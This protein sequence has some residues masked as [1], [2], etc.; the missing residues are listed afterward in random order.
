MGV[1]GFTFLCFSSLLTI[2]DPLAAAP[3]FLAMTSRS[4][5]RERRR[6]ALRASTVA[7]SL[8]LLFALGGKLIFG[9]FGITIEAMRIAGGIIFFIMALPMLVN[10]PR[11]ERETAEAVGDPSVVPLG[12][13]VICG[14]GAIT[15]VMVLMGQSSSGWHVASLVAAIVLV[16]ATTALFLVISPAILRVVGRSGLKVVTQVMGLIICV[17]G[18]QFILDGLRPVVI[19]I[20]SIPR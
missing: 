10:S 16:V 2:I 12:M 11:E 17:V 9:A 19:G 1:L 4:S 15:T 3:I 5:A 20:L 18:I 8:L 6:I 13:P 14:P 7:L